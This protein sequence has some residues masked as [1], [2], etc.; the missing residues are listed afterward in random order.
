MSDYPQTI[1]FP[2]TQLNSTLK[3]EYI[4]LKKKKK[5]SGQVTASIY[6]C[7]RFEQLKD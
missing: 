4:R 6:K 7:T 3:L 1:L 2:F 5:K